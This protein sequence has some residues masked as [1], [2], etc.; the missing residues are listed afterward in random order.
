[1]ADDQV[2]VVEGAGMGGAEMS[3]Q[4]IH[5]SHNKWQFPSAASV[6]NRIG[7]VQTYLASRLG[8]GVVVDGY[9]L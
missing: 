3:R 1:M 5:T 4:L 6:K 2:E 9:T 7:D 8:S